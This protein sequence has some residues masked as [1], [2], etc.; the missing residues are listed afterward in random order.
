ML[1]TTA[2]SGIRERCNF[3]QHVSGWRH[4]NLKGTLLSKHHKAFRPTFIT[5]ITSIPFTTRCAAASRLGR[6][7]RIRNQSFAGC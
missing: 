2:R 7:G 6:L 5:F 3:A 1:S 4:R